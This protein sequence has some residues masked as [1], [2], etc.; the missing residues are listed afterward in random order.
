MYD[1]TP[2]IDSITTWLNNTFSSFWAGFITMVLLG[3]ALLL[4]YAVLGLYLVY[5]ER[6]I[7]ARMQNR[8][9]PNRVGPGGLFQTIADLIKLLMKELIYIRN[10]DSFL[11][12]I[13]P[14]IVIVASIMAIGSI[15]FAKGLQAI[16]LTRLWKFL[17][18]SSMEKH[19]PNRES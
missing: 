18:H 11:F 8:L 6:K 16:D 2:L 19:F 9:G 13:A 5:A 14:F 12:N 10:A 7:C 4:F 17:G 15:P 1:F 3:V